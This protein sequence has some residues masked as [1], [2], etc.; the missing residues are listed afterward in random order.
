MLNPACEFVS[1]WDSGWCRLTTSC[2]DVVAADNGPIRVYSCGPVEQ[3]SPEPTLPRPAI[4]SAVS[5]P[6]PATPPPPPTA[7]P[8]ASP[9]KSCTNLVYDTNR[10]CSDEPAIFTGFK[11]AAEC[12]AACEHDHVCEFVSWDSGWCRLTT[13]CFDV[14]AAD[15]GTVRVYSCGSVEQGS[16]STL[17]LAPSIEK[18]FQIRGT[19]SD[20]FRPLHKASTPLRSIHRSSRPY[21]SVDPRTQGVNLDVALPDSGTWH[22]R[23][24]SA[25]QMAAIALAGFESVRV[26][27]P[28]PSPSPPVKACTTLIFDNTQTTSPYSRDLR[29]ELGAN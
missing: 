1:Y 8:T 9:L 19:G 20:P 22:K 3:G 23:Q 27:M 10:F 4:P 12:Q 2:V 13:S 11:A 17:P 24:F 6:P 18:S 14:V 7:V 5:A 16:S 26:Y 25:N 15:H 28:P 21:P 29:H